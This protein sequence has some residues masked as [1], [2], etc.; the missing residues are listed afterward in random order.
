MV[1]SVGRRGPSVLLWLGVAGLATLDLSAASFPEP[2]PATRSEAVTTLC[3]PSAS[4][5]P[6][7]RTRV[8]EL[9]TE[10]RLAPL[11]IR[12]AAAVLS[13]SAPLMD[14][15]DFR[16]PDDL[17]IRYTTSPASLD[18][19][20]PADG[21][22]NGVPDIVEGVALG[23]WQARGLLQRQL[24]LP[25]AL[26]TDVALVELGDRID[27][28]LI[29]GADDSWSLVLDATPLDGAEGARRSAI[30]LYA[31][32]VARSLSTMPSRWAEA[33]AAWTVLSVDG[34][35]DAEATALLSQRTRSLHAGLDADPGAGDSLWLAFLEE[36]YGLA[37]VRATIEDLGRLPPALALDSAVRR[38]TSDDLRAAFREFHLWTVLVGDRADSRHFPFAARLAS[39]TFAT[40]AEGLPALAIRESAPVA[41][42]GASHVLL[43]PDESHGGLHVRFEGDAL[44]SWDVDLVL[45]AFGGALRRVPV[46]VGPDGR[47]EVTV[48][49]PGVRD[50]LL[51]V[52]NL[53]SSD[54]GAHRYSVTA[55]HEP[56]FPFELASLEAAWTPEA[57][58]VLVSWET[59]SEQSLVG[60]N[61]VRADVE[62]GLE[63]VINPVWVPAMGDRDE[64][65]AYRFLDPSADP[66]RA[67]AYRIEGVTNEGIAAASRSVLAPRRV[68]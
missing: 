48:P 23:A 54:D 4:Q 11:G 8:I 42:L 35:P 19:T 68:R 29:P 58:G 24:E 30:R 63:V 22:G 27:G 50:A 5:G 55:F 64:P 39:P 18:R 66:E 59:T 56:R 31:Y 57:R 46:S 20:D 44:A 53:S 65:A 60:F 67:Y 13:R 14:E 36:A 45:A 26:V 3:P 49:L 2:R 6:C 62:S 47:G 28:Y 32:A 17:H 40:S 61:V 10:A 12:R 34:A 33:V 1:W 7:V 21:S 15:R 37:A 38:T 43:V 16:G 52:R 41:P 51:L 9:A 25:R